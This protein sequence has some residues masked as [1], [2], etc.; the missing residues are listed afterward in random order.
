VRRLRV[1]ARHTGG[2]AALSERDPAPSR[3]VVAR[4]LIALVAILLIA[5]FVALVRDH[6]IGT[7]ASTRIVSNSGMSAAEWRD[8]MHDFERAHL[9]DPSS[10]WSLIQAQYELLRDKDAALRRAEGVLRREPENLSAW[11]VVLRATQGVDEQRNREAAAAIHRLN[12]LP[13]GG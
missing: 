6:A 5:W 9:L 13:A 8:A 2:V 12:P 7:D 1:P 3:T 4:A 11:W 10:D